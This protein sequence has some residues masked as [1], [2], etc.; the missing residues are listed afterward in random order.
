MRIQIC[1]RLHKPDAV[2]YYSKAYIPL[3]HDRVGLFDLARECESQLEEAR[4]I[5][6]ALEDNVVIASCLP[7][8][9]DID[10]SSL[11]ALEVLHV[12]WRIYSLKRVNTGSGGSIKNLWT[13]ALGWVLMRTPM[14]RLFQIDQKNQ[15]A[16]GSHQPTGQNI[17][18]QTLQPLQ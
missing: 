17:L 12:G 14:L 5:F 1:F 7:Y 3:R 18:R 2:Y 11:S 4:G 10:V 16:P 13:G 9:T 6:L 8:G 15:I